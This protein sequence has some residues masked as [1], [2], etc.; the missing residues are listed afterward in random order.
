MK[1]HQFIFTFLHIWEFGKISVS[2]FEFR[3]P[4]NAHLCQR[5]FHSMPI[6][7][8][9]YSNQ[10]PSVT[11]RAPI[12]AH[13]WHSEL[14]SMP[15]SGN[16]YSNQCPCIRTLIS[17]N[18]CHQC[19]SIPTMPTNAQAIYFTICRKI[20]YHQASGTIHLYTYPYILIF[21]IQILF[22]AR[23]KSAITN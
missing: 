4:T 9:Q 23:Y 7:G 10:C 3:I 15:N 5:G 14:Q 8:N 13:Q 2:L 1:K 18:Q 17:A 11:S 21:Y 6:S 12:N 20:N 19:P 22:R 16:Q